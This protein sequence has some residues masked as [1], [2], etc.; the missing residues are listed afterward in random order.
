MNAVQLSVF[1]L[2]PIPS[3]ASPSTVLRNTIDLARHAES[4]GYRRYWF[5]EHHNTG[6]FA[7]A[8]PEIMI[9]QVA[10][11]TRTLRVGAGG[12]MLPNHSPLKVAETFRLLHALFPGRIDLG[13][14]RSSG[15]DA[16]TARALGRT[17]ED[18]FPAQVEELI[19]YF[20][21]DGTP[22]GA[23]PG[24][25]RAIPAGVPMP[26]LWILGTSDYGAA[27]AAQRGHRFAFAHHINPSGCVASL[28][29]YRAHFRPSAPGSN[30][31]SILALSVLCTESE[32]MVQ[33][34]EAFRHL[35]MLQFN[36]GLY[37]QPMPTLEEARTYP[38]T[39]S[40]RASFEIYRRQVFVGTPSRVQAFIGDLAS[41]CE[42]DEVMILSNLPDHRLRLR[43]Y[44]LVAE[45]L[46]RANTKD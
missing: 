25:V 19:G 18:D 27:F 17:H 32:A 39:E 20:A 37:D 23:F 7:S 42:A 21:D 6:L 29:A 4:L 31:R 12:M 44:E 43:S 8:T 16:H 11:A 22:R 38:W 46:Q 10:A 9:G 14:G 5:A 26:E 3:G 35:A 30:A 45:A 41:E 36:K 24:D 33:D 40:D 13:I 28:R 1:D 2:C 34:F 15:A